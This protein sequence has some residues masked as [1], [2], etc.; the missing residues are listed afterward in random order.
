[1]NHSLKLFVASILVVIALRF[2]VFGPDIDSGPQSEGPLLFYCAAG[3]K[4]PVEA[5]AREYEREYGVPIRLEY[6]GSGALLAKITVSEQGDL[7]LAADDSYLDIGREKGLV[8]EMLP[9]AVLRPVIAVRD[10]NPEK[11]FS[12]Q[13][14]L[15]PDVR[16]ALANPDAASVGR[17]TKRILAKSGDWEAI[18]KRAKVFKP[19]VGD[20]ANDIKLGTV[21]A[22]IIWDATAR[23]YPELEAVH[24]PLFDGETSSISVGVLRSTERPAAALRFA[25]FL[26]SR[27][28]GMPHFKKYGYETVE[29]DVWEEKPE[30]VFFSGGVNRLA[31]ED[32]IRQFEQR[33]GVTITS[34]YDGCGILCANMKALEGSEKFPDAYFSCDVSFMTQVGNL[35]Q[36]PT[37]ISETDMVII[38]AKD[39]PRGIKRL[40]DLAAPGLKIGVANPKQSALGALTEALLREMGLFESVNRNVRVH[41][42]K[43]DFLVNQM[44]VG[45]LDA[46]IVYEA[47]TPNVRDE[48]EVIRVDHPA[49]KAIQPFAVSRS[50][51]HKYLT[52]RLMDAMKSAQ[53]RTRFTETGF[54]WLVPLDAP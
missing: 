22:G 25:R 41:T 32:T 31:V 23:Q 16:L 52:Q 10:G 14:L 20:V 1:M 46:A 28:R 44:Q 7:Y 24:L 11:I 6:A 54:R 42:P 18:E 29:G 4:P 50:S 40:A 19:T 34:V 9:L 8:D 48:L 47:N 15:R 51:K 53:S 13:D 30:L 17:Q 49:A 43:A 39:N 45:A 21:D 36:P 33:E 26:Q 12:I 35:F 2:L 27:D 38:T 3:I 5:I 37:D